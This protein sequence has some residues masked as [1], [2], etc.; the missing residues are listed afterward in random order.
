MNFFGHCYVACWTGHDP[1]F[2]LGAMLPDFASMSGGRLGEVT[3][4]RIAAGIQHH[5]RT[6]AVF[7]AAP[8]F[9][10]LM[11]QSNE[12]MSGS[13]RW[14]S[15]RAVAH[16]GVELFVD[17]HLVHRGEAP[18]QRTYSHALRRGEPADLGAALGWKKKA[19]RDRFESLRQRLLSY[20][21]PPEIGQPKVVSARLQRALRDRDRLRI[22]PDELAAVENELQSMQADVASEADA[23]LD[24]VRRGLEAKG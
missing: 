10:Q 18:P 9:I 8:T 1:A 23:L 13:V 20:A 21:L 24:E 12:R 11:R 3:D 17:A 2:A 6:D 4:E 7:H 16:I 14:G 5:L 19:T 15:A 22:L